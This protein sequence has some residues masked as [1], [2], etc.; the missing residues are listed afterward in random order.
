LT[1]VRSAFAWA[2][3][4]SALVH[5]ALVVV[6]LAG[7][8]RSAMVQPP[9][10]LDVAIVPVPQ[11]RLA[12]ALALAVASPLALPL[13]ARPPPVPPREV[14][15][16][17]EHAPATPASRGAGGPGLVEARLLTDRARIG[18][19]L[20]R[21]IT[22]FPVE[23]GTP[24]RLSAPITVSYPP[25]LLAAGREDDVAL[26]VVVDAEGR[27]EEVQVTDGSADFAGAAVAAVQAAR[28]V[29]ATNN[30]R[31]IRFPIALEFK[32]ALPQ[33]AA[34]AAASTA[35]DDRR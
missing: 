30:R 12:P 17:L 14:L 6:P 27:V 7:G 32:F 9:P 28:F 16:P 3:C 35:G 11:D 13:T 1:G 33:G 24:V 15:W 31:P 5:A 8:E 20:E 4:G 22:E 34:A 29:P 23:I 21:Q 19:V 10:D 26:W 18:E 2:L 25:R